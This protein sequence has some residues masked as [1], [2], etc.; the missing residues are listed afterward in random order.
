[1]SAARLEDVN[2]IAE[3]TNVVPVTRKVDGLAADLTQSFPPY[4]VTVLKV[5]STQHSEARG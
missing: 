4:S 5:G 3:P 2:S 1:M